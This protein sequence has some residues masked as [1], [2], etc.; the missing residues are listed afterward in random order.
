MRRKAEWTGE[1]MNDWAPELGGSDDLECYRAK[2]RS[3]LDTLCGVVPNRRTGSSGNREATGFF[4]EAVLSW[5]YRIDATPFKCLDHERGGVSLD[6][7]GRA[8]EVSISPYSLGCDV[9]AELAVVSSVA[10]LQSSVC[11]GRLLLLKGNICAEQ[12]T[13]KDYPFYNVE[14]HQRIVSLLEEKQPAAIITAT[15]KLPEQVGALD[16]FP[17]LVDGSFDIPSVFCREVVGDELARRQGE[18]FRLQMDARRVPSTACNVIASSNSG[19]RSKIVITAHIDAYED[20]PGA[21]DNASGTVVLLL[22]AEMLAGF[23]SGP[24]LEIAALNGEDHYSAAGQL[25]Y[26]KRYGGELNRVVLAINAD[27]V[28]YRSGRSAFSLYG[29]PAEIERLAREILG[30]FTG[31]VEGE[32]WYTGDH[33]IFGQQGVP[34]LAVTA[35]RMPDL[36]RTVTHTSRD[37]PDLIDET[38]LVEVARALKALVRALATM[39][40]T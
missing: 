20:S 28:G 37:T 30:R 10:E 36:M 17:L 8:F 19:T 25:D 29:C 21:S 31:L 2:A 32:P 9:S 39:M 11:E 27:D 14:G 15:G 3:Y 23:P 18:L 38:K 12:L 24:R 6:Y 33:M 34:A 26:L 40:E 4:A 1:Q 16:P 13:P 7:E 22:L 35:E 5:G